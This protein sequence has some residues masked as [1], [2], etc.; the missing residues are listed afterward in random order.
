MKSILTGIAKMRPNA[1]TILATVGMF[2]MIFEL[3]G[4][5]NEVHQM[6]SEQIKNAFYALPDST[7]KALKA[8]H[9][10]KKFENSVTV[11][12]SVEVEGDVHVQEPVEVDIDR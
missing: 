7:Q 6:R 11:N 4:I 10:E 12:G 2:V 9:R 1:R 3:G 8:N 5:W